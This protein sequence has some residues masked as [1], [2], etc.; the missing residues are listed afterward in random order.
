MKKSHKTLLTIVLLAAAVVGLT[1]VRDYLQR[2]DEAA[3]QSGR[4]YA[5]AAPAEHPALLWYQEQFSEKEILLACNADING[6]SREDLVVITR[7]EQGA[8]EAVALL[9]EEAG[10]YTVTAPIP[11]PQQHQKMR[12]FN[13]D[14]EPELEFLMTGDKNGM[15]GYAVY[16]VTE[17]ALTNLFGEGMEDCC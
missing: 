5:Q 16:Q 8:A 1:A 13:M 7:A 11:A 4:Q 10:G 14:K 9:A 17:G 3:P 12:F 6:D 2:A 15:V